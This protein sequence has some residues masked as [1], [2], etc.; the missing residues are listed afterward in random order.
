[1]LIKQVNKRRYSVENHFAQNSK[2]NLN[3]SP[4][5]FIGEYWVLLVTFCHVDMCQNFTSRK[6][7]LLMRICFTS[8]VFPCF[9]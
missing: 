3:Q 4:N 7:L 1:M 6:L 9:L 2:G 5:D 8:N